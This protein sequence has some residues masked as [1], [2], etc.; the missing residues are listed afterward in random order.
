MLGYIIWTLSE[1]VNNDLEDCK[2]PYVS[3]LDL[4]SNLHLGTEE[5]TKSQP[6]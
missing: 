6:G 1:R 5:H 2:L 4:P 3:E